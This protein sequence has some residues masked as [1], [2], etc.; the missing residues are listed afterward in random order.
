MSKR[1]TVIGDGG[2]GT[3]LG[4][5]LQRNG[6]QVTMWGYDPDY[7]A[8][9]RERGENYAYLPGVPLPEEL[10]WTAD[11]E[12]AT[13]DAEA[14][15]IAVPTKFYPTTLSRFKGHI[16]LDAPVVSVSKGLVDN[17][18]LTD[19]AKDALGLTFISA[20]SGPS[21]AEEV[22]REAPTAVTVASDHPPFADL[23][24]Q[25]FNNQRFRVYTC[26]LYTSDAADE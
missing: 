4:L 17:R 15:V 19:V 6:H 2:W 9:V 23:F 1:I 11:I 21:H 13:R 5:V 16:S 24:Q 22:A 7:I 25:L 14:Y 3:A 26:L 20:L 10:Y 12:E 8:E 18:V